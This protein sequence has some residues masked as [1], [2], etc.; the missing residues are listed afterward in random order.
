MNNR[1]GGNG[2][3][4]VSTIVPSVMARLR[5]GASRATIYLRATRFALAYIAPLY[6]DAGITPTDAGMA[7]IVGQLLELHGYPTND[8]T[9]R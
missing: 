6:R 3:H 5:P 8:A 9:T 4:H 2:P 7:T 1:Y